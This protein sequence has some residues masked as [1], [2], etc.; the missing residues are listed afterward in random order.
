MPLAILSLQQG[1]GPA[2]PPPDRP[3]RPGDPRSAA[4]DD[5]LRPPVPRVAAAGAGDPRPR[6]GRPVLHVNYSTG[7]VNWAVPNVPVNSVLFPEAFSCGPHLIRG[8]TRACRPADGVRAPAL[9]QSVV[10]GK[11]VDAQGKPVEG[12]TVTVRSDRA[13]IARRRPRPISNGRVPAGRPRVRARTRSR[14][15][16]TGVGRQI[17]AGERHAGPTSRAD[18]HAQ[19]RRAALGRP[20]RAKAAGASCRRWPAQRDRRDE[21]R[22]A[23]TRRSP[24]QRD[25]RQGADVRRLLLQPRHRLHRASSSTPRP[26][27]AFKKVDRAEAGCGR[28]LHRPGERLQRAEEVRSGGRGRARRRAALRRGRRRRQRGGDATTRA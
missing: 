10:R 7:T 5:G 14:R 9:A 19:R 4:A 6:C 20:S 28:A 11:V 21:G 13:R 26:K 2:D 18:L 8:V 27:T 25:H 1:L 3:R 22:A 23:T 17:A 12:A 16:R 24:V 15:R